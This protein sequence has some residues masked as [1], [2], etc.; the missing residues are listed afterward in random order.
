MGTPNTING[1]ASSEF[2]S[3][4]S[5]DDD[6]S[7]Q[8]GDDTLHGAAGS[9][10]L[11][12]GLNG[13]FLDIA[14]YYD[15]PSAVN[16]DLQ[17]GTADDGWGA[18]DTLVAIEALNGSAFGD[19]LRG[20]S[21]NNWFDG[22]TGDDVIDGR[23]GFDTVFYEQAKI[24]FDINLST[25]RAKALDGSETDT[26]I[27]VEAVHGTQH[28]DKITLSNASGNVFGR[29]GHDT[30][31]GG[32]GNDHLIGGSGDDLID[33]R[34]GRNTASYFVDGSDEAGQPEHG[35]VVNL[36]A[37]EATDNWGARD[38]LYNIQDVSGS[39]LDDLI[40]G[41]Q[42][43]NYLSGQGGDDTLVGRGGSDYLIGSAGSDVLNGGTGPFMD[44]VDYFDSPTGVNVDLEAGSADDGWGSTDILLNI[45]AVNGSAHDDLLKGT[46]TN[47][48]FRGGTGNDTIDGR[49]GSDIVFYEEANSGLIINLRD[50]IVEALDGSETDTLISIE[51]THGTRFD[52][53]ITLSNTD[54]YASGRAGDD[55]LDGLGGNDFIIG[56]SGD[57]T[58]DG[59]GGRNSVGYS[60]DGYDTEG[61]ARRGV[62]VDLAK[63][64]ATDSWGGRDKLYNIQDVTGSNFA[65]ALNGND[66]DNFF[67]GG[68]GHDLIDG[69]GGHDVASY[70][71]ATVGFNIDLGSGKARALDGS[72]TDTLISIEA[73][74]GSQSGDVIVL[75][76]AGGGAIARGGNDTIRGGLG[77][78]N[79]TAGSGDDM[80]D[81]GVGSGW[82]SVS[83]W[84]D[85]YDAAGQS[86]MGVSVDL[87]AHTA[88]DNWG[89]HDTLYN[90]QD[91]R[92]SDF[93]DLI[94]G[95]AAD[96]SFTGMNG[97][98]TFVGGGGYDTIAWRGERGEQ[99]VSV[100]ASKGTAID[101]YG[102]TDVF[103]G[104]RDFG[105]TDRSDT[106]I[107]SAEDDFIQAFAG[108]DTIDGR[109]GRNTIAYHREGGANGIIF[110]FTK[111]EAIDTYGNTDTF[112]NIYGVRASMMGD[113]LIGDG[114]DNSFQGMRGSDTI[115]GGGGRDQI[116]YHSEAGRGAINGIAANLQEER[117]RDG[118]GDTDIVSEV[119]DVRGT[120]FGDQIIGNGA[121]NWLRGD[122]G[123][124]TLQGGG[125]DDVLDGG[126]GSDIAVFSGSASDYSITRLAA[127]KLLI[128]DKRATPLDGT[129][130]LSGVEQ[131]QFSDK[132]YNVDDLLKVSNKPPVVK[133]QTFVGSEDDGVSGT[134]A[135]SDP[136]WDALTFTLVKPVAGL[137]L[138]PDGSF[139]YEA[140]DSSG[141]GQTSTVTFQVKV[142]D[143][144]LTSTA[145]TITLKVTGSNDAPEAVDDLLAF[146]AAPGKVITIQAASLLKN[147]TDPDKGDT[148]AIDAASFGAFTQPSFGKL[149]ISGQNLIYTPG[150]E[151]LKLKGSQTLTDTFTY[152]MKDKFG[153]T[154]EAVVT[155][156]L[157][158]QN[159]APK[160]AA[161]TFVGT[162]NDG[163][164]G[165]IIGTDSNDDDLS[166]SLVKP[167][168]GLSLNP[169]GSFTY[170][171][172]DS[173][174]EGK[175]GK[176]T[177]QVKATDGLLI[178]S[179]ATMTLTIAGRN[180]A[181]EALD[182]VVGYASKG[183]VAAVIQGS[184]LLK[185][186]L[187]P[188]KGDTKVI[189]AAYAND[190][191]A[192]QVT[193]IKGVI[194]YK[195]A[196]AFTKIGSGD[197]LTDTFTYEMMDK[198]G[199]SSRADVTINLTGQTVSATG[200]AN[201]TANADN[202]TIDLADLNN[203]KVNADGTA[204]SFATVN[205]F[206]SGSDRVYLIHGSE[207]FAP[208]DEI[209]DYGNL[210]LKEAAN[211]AADYLMS[212][213]A[214]ATAFEV[215]GSTFIYSDANGTGAFDAGDGLLK[216]AGA[217][218]LTFELDYFI[219]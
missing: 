146:T 197:N 72:E 174:G 31:Y 23:G 10:I 2:L 42:Q 172:D 114:N 155:L 208:T 156:V 164:T 16:A 75:S 54:G 211:V 165:R 204:K 196:A 175:M 56:G 121:S 26:I 67:R 153:S 190:E 87:S 106:F 214:T 65:D 9:D 73:V 38:E 192:G 49:G 24:G 201:L 189:T 43:D 57:D 80:I 35:I 88:T 46:E 28:S 159:V 6:I 144:L 124:D 21:G 15:S 33:G 3:G 25:G 76:N 213:E 8:A 210:T 22:R 125:G 93:S 74:N 98:D 219:V 168:A 48:W 4:T 123:D 141:E 113:V 171:A 198:A 191:T 86:I 137:A 160:V 36:A 110:D 128:S 166:F 47:N 149:A 167:V 212:V 78:D 34:G 83:Y 32:A 145:A 183:G 69:R 120:Q 162:E 127:G 138:N 205:N 193:F 130:T 59:G 84:D 108:N 188:D 139:T 100:D 150:D 40:E 104:I 173:L 63:G 52:D 207:L 112:K 90:I 157:S 14:D 131:V 44:T 97:E 170:E 66:S 96:N 163:V 154:S 216:L 119:E 13:P 62:V 107:G 41:D 215:E 5:G 136:N 105:L 126:N 178:S 50:G 61:P 151:V 53:Q 29:G 132:I 148:K 181:P 152:V 206:A 37:H 158:G 134:L 203:V 133:A 142:T 194:S 218:D 116:S 95:D 45:E 81:G 118:F 71:D 102:K 186:D 12:G 199:A 182:D 217:T 30:I 82:N 91:V 129:D 68:A 115:T 64:E 187:D 51:G 202:V 55:V 17:T 200:T 177:F 92:G 122:D 135:A 209:I 179:A 169:D 1:T 70:E 103:S 176:V 101:T 27:N 58:I 161:Q 79:I 180:D 18:R 11:N 7:G 111:G 39:H 143:G 185:N 184:S 195:P 140:V 60:D 77:N 99:G 147:D 109:G 20:D 19:T 89:G 85:G 117:V 94:I